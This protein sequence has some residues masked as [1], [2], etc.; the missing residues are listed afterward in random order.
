MNAEP[1]T[2]SGSSDKKPRV[3]V[4]RGLTKSF[5]DKL[6]NDA[7]DFEVRR[8]EIHALLGE[9]GAG[10][11][12]LISI[13]CGQYRPDAGTVRVGDSELTT[14][15][16]RSALR[17]GIGVVH[18]D[19]RLVPRFTVTENI[20]LGTH[21]WGNRAAAERVANVAHQ[22]GF[23]VD[24]AARVASL[25]VGEQQQVAILRLLFRGLDILMLD[26][27][28]AVLSPQQATQ[29]FASLRRLTEQG[30]AV[31]LIT[32]RLQEVSAAADRVTVLRH[33]R[34]IASREVQGLT[35]RDLARMMVGEDV[36]ETTHVSPLAPGKPVV[37]LRQVYTSSRS[38]RGLAGLDLIVHAGE[39]VGIA[40][41]SGNGQLDLAELV[42]GI[43]DP[44]RGERVTSAQLVGFIPEDRLATGLVGPMTIAENLALRRYHRPPLSSRFWL[45]RGRMRDLARLLVTRY[46]IPTSDLDASVAEL[47]GGGHQRVLTAR[48]MH[49]DPDLLVA[50]QPSRGLDVASA[51]AIRR[52]LLDARQRGAAILLISEDLDELLELADRVVVLFRGR[53]AGTFPRGGAD[54]AT[55][56]LLM[57]GG[58]ET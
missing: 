42:A 25:S 39:I 47:S 40:G 9:N 57:A 7:I 38:G 16:P 43:I 32:H 21:D 52:Q 51:E 12:T 13:L 8:G 19:F 48:E 23:S 49:E 27:P 55:L 30:K 26:E 11:S 22:V 53:A 50:A 15:S 1:G 3:L 18:Q 54:R 33:G 17:A 41:V 31:V 58:S 2:A 36:P 14:G 4:A 45:W 10:K 44:D 35:H 46:V 5:A 6:A 56:G 34:V 20:V 24:P 37:E 28:T 29:L